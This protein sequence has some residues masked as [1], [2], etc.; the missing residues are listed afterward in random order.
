MLNTSFAFLAMHD[1]KPRWATF[2]SPKGT[3][4]MAKKK[5]KKGVYKGE[6]GSSAKKLRFLG[7]LRTR[8]AELSRRSDEAQR[9]AQRDIFRIRNMG[10]DY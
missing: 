3:A 6:G 4:H 5:I 9:D 7:E 2:K 8:A 10:L 1:R